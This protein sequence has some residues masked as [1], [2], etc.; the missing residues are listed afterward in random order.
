MV[1]G[2]RKGAPLRVQAIEESQPTTDVDRTLVSCGKVIADTELRIVDVEQD[3]SAPEGE[4]GEIWVSGPSVVEGYWSNF[5][6]ND[7]TFDA[8]L[9][10]ASSDKRWLRTGD[11]G[12]LEQGELFVTGRLKDLLAQKILKQ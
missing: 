6:Q 8:E 4:I 3:R 2:A 9:S 1:T 12:F 11:Y 10:D 5:D 7:K